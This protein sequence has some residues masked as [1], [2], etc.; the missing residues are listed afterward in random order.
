MKHSLGRVAVDIDPHGRRMVVL[1]QVAT[2]VHNLD[3][4]LIGKGSAA[5]DG[6][7]G[8]IQIND[9]LMRRADTHGKID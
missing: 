2:S 9:E 6:A 7:V 5:S 4:R 1:Q 3:A 8:G